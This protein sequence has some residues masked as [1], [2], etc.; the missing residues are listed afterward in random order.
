MEITIEVADFLL[1]SFF[2]ANSSLLIIECISCLRSTLVACMIILFMQSCFFRIWRWTRCLSEGEMISRNLSNSS[3]L[4]LESWVL[5][6]YLR[7]DSAVSLVMLMLAM[8]L[9]E[10]STFT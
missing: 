5:R 3:Y 4:S 9:L 7:M 6:R 2:W 1:I 10:E 8:T